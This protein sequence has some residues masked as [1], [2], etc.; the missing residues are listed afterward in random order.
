LRNEYLEHTI[1]H[2]SFLMKLKIK[3][4]LKDLFPGVNLSN[5]RIN[6]IADRLKITE[7]SEIDQALQDANELMDFAAIAKQ[8]DRVRTLEAN[9]KKPNPAPD[10]DPT[11]DPTPNPKP[12]GQVDIA[13]LIQDALNPLLQE[14]AG[15]KAGKT[16]ETRKQA[17]EAKLKDVNPI[18]KEVYLENFDPA[19][20]ETDEAFQEYMTAT[21][22]KISDATQ[23]LTDQGLGQ[24]SRPFQSAGAGSTQTQA[25]S[26]IEK[27]SKASMPAEP[28]K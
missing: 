3:Q 20:F 5:D 16:H 15:L 6:A 9:A 8:D 24:S 21:E 28:A 18:L 4:R 13:K 27:W 1:N 23:K 10:A 12:E 19:K 17:F 26:D 25:K 14:V 11:P 7:E 22:T 2:Y